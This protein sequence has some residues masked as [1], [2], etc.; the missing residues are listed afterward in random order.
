MAELNTLVSDPYRRPPTLLLQ[1]R[2]LWACT[3]MGVELLVY[4]TGLTLL[5]WLCMIGD[6]ALLASFFRGFEVRHREQREQLLGFLLNRTA[7]LGWTPVHCAVYSDSTECLVF[8]MD[9]TKRYFGA[10]TLRHVADAPADI[11]HMVVGNA[12]RMIAAGIHHEN[13]TQEHI[14]NIAHNLI[15]D[16]ACDPSLA[17]HAPHQN[18]ALYGSICITGLTPVHVASMFCHKD[19]MDVLLECGADPRGRTFLEELDAHDVAVA[20]HNRNKLQYEVKRQ[21]DGVTSNEQKVH[22]A[23]EEVIRA[24]INRM[25]TEPGVKAKLSGMAARYSASSV[26]PHIVLCGLLFAYILFTRSDTDYYSANAMNEGILREEFVHE[27]NVSLQVFKE[28]AEMDELH[29]WLQGPFYHQLFPSN[30]SAGLFLG[31]WELVGSIRVTQMRGSVKDNCQPPNWWYD[32]ETPDVVRERYKNK[33]FTDTSEDMRGSWVHDI[34]YVSRATGQYWFLIPG[35]APNI[36][37]IDIP[38]EPSTAKVLLKSLENELDFNTRAFILWMVA[39]NPSVNSF[40]VVTALIEMPLEGTLYPHWEVSVMPERLFFLSSAEIV[41]YVFFTAYLVIYLI[42]FTAEE[43]LDAFSA[44]REFSNLRNAE[45]RKGLPMMEDEVMQDEVSPQPSPQHSPTL[46]PDPSSVSS[47]QYLRSANPLMTFGTPSHHSSDPTQPFLSQR[48]RRPSVFGQR[49]SKEKSS[50][51]RS[52][53]KTKRVSI[54]DREKAIRARAIKDVGAGSEIL[55]AMKNF[56]EVVI[57][58]LTE[59]WNFLDLLCLIFIYL[60][61]FTHFMLLGKRASVQQELTDYPPFDPFGGETE[62]FF[63]SFIPFKDWVVQ[64]NSVIA[65]VLILHFVKLLKYAQ[66]LPVVGPVICAIVKTCT[67][68]NVGVFLLVWQ[69]LTITFVFGLNI[70]F[71]A[72]ME[73]YKSLY[74]SF[75]TVQRHVLSDFDDFQKYYSTH[76]RLGPLLWLIFTYICHLLLLNLFIAV[77]SVDYTENLGKATEDWAWTLLE[78]YKQR[79]L[80]LCDPADS[81]S[82]IVW[83]KIGS[84]LHLTSFMKRGFNIKEVVQTK[85]KLEAEINSSDIYNRDY[86]FIRDHRHLANWNVVWPRVIQDA[87]EGDEVVARGHSRPAAA[88]VP[89]PT[90]HEV[91][92]NPDREPQDERGGGG[93]GEENPR[94]RRRSTVVPNEERVVDKARRMSMRLGRE[95]STSHLSTESERFNRTLG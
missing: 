13:L 7:K 94:R 75:Y 9:L 54:R 51:K 32:E 50:K 38:N 65:I 85:A 91:G 25:H 82:L 3:R 30:V 2:H 62:H 45:R 60:G 4:D 33:C 95:R 61:I 83:Y 35:N 18:S 5:H 43:L 74:D 55:G 87:H 12:D 11:S 86:E 90:L 69:F 10:E 63:S 67:S 37:T 64:Q 66:L 59:D 88:P 31:Y 26:L 49:T 58:Y 57:L 47:P 56:F 6:A 93:G 77:I 14:S 8:L 40:A 23:T 29:A 79:D 34:P 27:T 53:G 36:S 17:K 42:Y 41:Y 28:I 20:V 92:D 44:K 39:Y 80:N 81:A 76:T 73:G 70:I 52:P 22:E 16:P 84:M 15:A 19:G 71:G 24:S 1:Y 48:Q 46:L 78:K 21:T 68:L 89:A 72:N